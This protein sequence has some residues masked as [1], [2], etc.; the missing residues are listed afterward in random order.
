MACAIT[1][2]D[3]LQGQIRIAKTKKLDFVSDADEMLTS[4]TARK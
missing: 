3:D 1:T 2:C 4:T